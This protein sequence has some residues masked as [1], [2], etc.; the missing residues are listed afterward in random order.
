MS[1]TYPAI[2]D[3]IQTTDSMLNTIRALKISVEL[4]TGQRGAVAPTKVFVQTGT[5][6]AEQV[7]DMWV[8][9]TTNYLYFWSGTDWVYAKVA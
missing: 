4:L 2:P 1:K 7:G 3:P 8:N 5:P 9:T 6:T